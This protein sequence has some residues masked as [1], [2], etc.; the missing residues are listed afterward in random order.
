MDQAEQTHGPAPAV[1]DH[2]PRD[3]RDH[4]AGLRR[5]EHEP[6]LDQRDADVQ[7]EV[8]DEEGD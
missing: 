7:R 6:G 4:A 8:R 5:G 1:R 2:A 3:A